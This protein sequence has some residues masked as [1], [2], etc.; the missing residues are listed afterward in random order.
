MK[1]FRSPKVESDTLVD[2]GE[3]RQSLSAYFAPSPREPFKL[4]ANRC[5]HLDYQ[6][7]IRT[8]IEP[9][10]SEYKSAVYQN[11]P[12]VAVDTFIYFFK[13]PFNG[14]IRTHDTRILEQVIPQLY[15]WLRSVNSCPLLY[16][17]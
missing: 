2:S 4:R 17:T 3:F 5:G 1:H 16:Q 14:G 12:S 13:A 9:A 10:L 6:G 8:G 15:E 7:A 11:E